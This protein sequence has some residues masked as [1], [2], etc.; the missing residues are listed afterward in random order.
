MALRKWTT[1]DYP[2]RVKG[3]SLVGM[4]VYLT[5]KQGSEKLTLSGSDIEITDDGDDTLISYT[6]DQEQTG[7]FDE[8]R[9]LEIEVNWVVDG[10]RRATSISGIEIKRNLLEHTI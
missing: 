3:V 7:S 4:D 1:W 5:F 8:S 10:K 6:L 2:V 9:S